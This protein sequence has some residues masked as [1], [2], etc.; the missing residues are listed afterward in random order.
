MIRTYEVQLEGA[1]PLLMHSDN[2]EWADY[3][4]AWKADPSHKKTSTAGDDRSPAFRWIGSVYHDGK[5]ICIQQDNI[6]RCLMEG[7]AM[8]PVPGAKNN[9]TFKAQTQSGMKVDEMFIPLLN[10]GREIPWAPVAALKDEPSFPAHM[11]A[12]RGL[13]FALFVKRAKIKQSKHIRVR[14]R[15]DQW[16]LTFHLSV[17]DEQL[18]EDVLRSILE[19]SGQYKGL[20]DWR[21]G[22][23][24][25]GSFGMFRL[26]ALAEV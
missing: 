4:E 26:A 22:S 9:K 6:A 1:T 5:R 15:F 21:P 23:K 10:G 13:G 17:W 8:V 19:F 7:G 18:T 16:S 20:C 14:P 25:P 3:M 2:I 12:A 24:T 11:A